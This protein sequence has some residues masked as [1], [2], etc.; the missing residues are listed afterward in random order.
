MPTDDELQEVTQSI[1]H[2]KDLR[3]SVSEMSNSELNARLLEIRKARRS[4][5]GNPRTKTVRAPKIKPE[6]EVSSPLPEIPTA[7]QL[8]A[9]TPEE[10]LALRKRFG[11]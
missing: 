9:M 7:E 11:I 1:S 8:K 3:Q 6:V 5:E 2:L 4:G 10:L